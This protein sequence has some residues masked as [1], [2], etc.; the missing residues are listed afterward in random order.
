M[1]EG[2]CRSVAKTKIPVN[3]TLAATR[4][5]R[6]THEGITELAGPTQN[7]CQKPVSVLA[8]MGSPSHAATLVIR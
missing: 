3:S 4:L 8:Y 5:R 1:G 2:D 6:N 7:D